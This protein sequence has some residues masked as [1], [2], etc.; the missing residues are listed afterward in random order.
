MPP[1]HRTKAAQAKRLREKPE[2]PSFRNCLQWRSPEI[3]K[4]SMKILWNMFGFA[5]VLGTLLTLGLVI[6]EPMVLG[7]L[8][9]AYPLPFALIAML[10]VLVAGFWVRDMLWPFVVNAFVATREFVVDRSGARY[11]RDRRA[12]QLRAFIH[13]P[14]DEEPPPPVFKCGRNGV[15]IAEPWNDR[16]H[17]NDEQ[18]VWACSTFAYPERRRK[19]YAVLE[20]PVMSENPPDG[21]GVEF[22]PDDRQ[23][24]WH[25]GSVN[26]DDRYSR[27]SLFGRRRSGVLPLDP[28]EAQQS[29]YWFDLFGTSF[30]GGS[31]DEFYIAPVER[32]RLDAIRVIRARLTELDD[33]QPDKP[34]SIP[35]LIVDLPADALKPASNV[36]DPDFDAL[37][38]TSFL[39]LATADGIAWSLSICAGTPP[40]VTD[41][42]MDMVFREDAP[43]SG[44][45]HSIACRP[46]GL[47]TLASATLSLSWR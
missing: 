39:R 4:S 36:R 24:S 13:L 42:C 45:V 9:A 28:A 46:Y 15:K 19:R 41:K 8:Y 47:E 11:I 35:D 10:L 17:V 16:P 6:H 1:H 21:W 3:A 14:E 40:A 5:G 31:R 33:Q 18:V 26:A 7:E 2:C 44:I 12:C 30:G 34:R 32:F 25:T 20:P 29:D 37:P 43:G 23:R 38:D 22:S 27:H